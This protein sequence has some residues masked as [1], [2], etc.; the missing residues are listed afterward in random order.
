MNTYEHQFEHIMNIQFINISMIN[1][2]KITPQHIIIKL[3]K[4]KIKEKALKE[5]RGKNRHK[6]YVISPQNQ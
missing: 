2:K 6:L 3:L 5:T 1:K 4:S